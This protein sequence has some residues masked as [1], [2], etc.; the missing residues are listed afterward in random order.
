MMAFSLASEATVFDTGRTTACSNKP[1]KSKT[2]TN[3]L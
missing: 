2:K 3:S 1:T